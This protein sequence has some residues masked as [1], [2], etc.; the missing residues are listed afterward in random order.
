MD[1]WTRWFF[2][3]LIT[4]VLVVVGVFLFTSTNLFTRDGPQAPQLI[5][6]GGTPAAPTGAVDVPLSL[7]H[8]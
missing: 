8:I 3:G 5:D 1:N 7:I 2:V 6:V 4:F